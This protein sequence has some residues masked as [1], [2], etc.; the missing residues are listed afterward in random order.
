MLSFALLATL[1]AVPITASA[2]G[3]NLKFNGNGKFKIVIFSDVQDQFPVHQRVIRI[4]EQALARENPDL[5]VFLGDITELNIKDPEDDY[6][7]TVEQIFA[8]VVNAGIPYAIVFGNH[9]DQSATSGTRTDKE[10]MLSVIQSL[11]DCR[12]VDADPSLFG[13]GTCKIPIY[14]SSGNSVAFDLF[15]VDSNTYQTPTDGNSGYDNPHADQL[16]WLAANKDAGVNSLVFQ[17]IP[18]PEIYNLLTVD[19]GGSRTYGNK[20]YAMSLNSNASGSLG[21]FPCPPRYNDNTGEFAALKSM[22]GVLGVITGHDHLNDFT[23]TYDGIKMTAVPGMTYFNYG[24]ET[25]RGYGVIE[26]DESDL[27]TYNNHTVKF[28]E[29][30]AESGISTVTTFD[31]YDVITYA[32]LRKNGNPLSGDTYT[33][34]G[35]NDFSYNATSPSYSAIFKFRWIAGTNTGIQFSFDFGNGSNISYPFGVWVKKPNDNSAGENGAWHLK[36]SAPKLI[37][38]MASAVTEGDI[39]DIEIGRLKVLT[40]APQHLGEYYIYLKVNGEL[41]SWTY[42]NTSED[43]QYMSGGAL[44]QVSNNIRFADWG[45]YGNKISAYAEEAYEEYDVVSY[46]DLLDTGNHAL[47]ADGTT[48]TAKNNVFHYDATSATHSAV[49]KFRWVAGNNNR[50]QVH[51]G[52]YG[53]ANNFAYRIYDT[54]LIQRNPEKILA[55]DFDINEGDE[56]DI[57]VA[58][59]MT[60]AGVNAGKYYTYFKVNGVTVFAKCVSA[61]ESNTTSYLSDTLQMNLNDDSSY[62]TIKP[63]PEP[64]MGPYAAYDVIT[65]SDLLDTGNNHLSAGGKTLTAQN[66]LF[67]Y[68][69]TSSTHSVI[70]KFR[71]VAGAAVYFQMF[72]GAYRSGDPFAYRLKDDAKT[73]EKRYSPG[74]ASKTLGHTVTEGET[75]DFEIA[76]LKVIE[77]ENAGKYYT[78]LKANDNL[79][80]EEYVTSDKISG[81]DLDDSIQLNLNGSNSCVIMA[82]PAELEPSDAQYYKYDEIDYEDLLYNGSALSSETTLGNRVLT[83]YRTSPTYSAILR[84]RWKAASPDTQFQL[85]FDRLGAQNAINYMFGIQLYSAAADS[86]NHPNGRVW[87]RPGYGPSVDFTK[88]VQAGSTYDIEFARL[89]VKNGENAG[90][91][92]MYF[93]MNG[94]LI[95][96]SYVAADV[97]DDSGNYVSKPNDVACHLSNEIYITYWG[98]GGNDKICAIPEEDTFVDYDEVYYSDLLYNGSPVAAERS[99]QGRMYTYNKTS[100][101]G[102]AIL[103]IRWKNADPATQFQISFDRKGSNNAINYMFGVQLY[104]ASAQYP[105]GRVYLRPGYGPSVAFT[106]PIQAG[107]NYD[108]EFARLKVATGPNA[109]KYY[110]YFKMNDVL[111]AEDYVAANVVDSVGNYTSSPDSTACHISNEMYITFWGGSGSTITNPAYSETYYDYDEVGYED[112]LLG[113]NP[114]TASRT[115]LGSTR[116]FTYNRTSDTYSV[117]LKYCWTAGTYASNK[118]YYVFYFDAWAGSAYPFA[119]AVKSPGY[120]SLGAAAGANGAWHIDPSAA[121]NIVQ[122]STPIVTGNNY[123]IEHGRIKVKTGPQKD[124]YYVYLKVD[125]V[126]VFGYYYDGVTGNTYKNGAGTLTN[127]LKFTSGN[128]TSYISSATND[129]YDTTDQVYYSDLSVGGSPVE[130]ERSGSGTTYTY[131]KTSSSGSAILKIR[132]KNANPATQ[133]QMSFDRKGS[134]N[135]INYMFGVQLFTPTT[136]Y[137]NGYVWLRPGYGPKAALLA[138][139][140]EGQN[141]DIE[142]ARIKVMGGPNAGKYYMYIKINNA[143]IAEDYFDSSVVD[144]GGNYNSYPGPVNCQ[145]SNKIYI[146][147][148]GG[149]GATITEPETFADYDIVNFYDLY[150]NGNRVGNELDMGGGGRTFTF[151]QTSDT[152]STILKY[153]WRV[154]GGT[155]FQLSFDT[156]GG[157]GFEY[158]F[159]AQLFAPESGYPNGYIWMRPGYG[160]KIALSSAIADGDYYNVEYA[161][162]KV[163]DG[164]YAGK[165]CLY[166]KIGDIFYAKEYFGVSVT[167]GNYTSKPGDIVCSI[168]NEIYLTFWGA[169]SN[170]KITNYREATYNHTGL[171][172]DLNGDSSV[173]ALDLQKL[174]KAVVDLLDMSDLPDGVADYNNDGDVSVFDMVAMKKTFI[175]TNSYAKSGSLALGMQ[176]HLNEDN[177]KTAQYIADASATLGASVYRLSM[178]IHQLYYPTATNNAS[179]RS[180]NMDTF[181]SMVSA[182]KAKGITKILYVTD[183]FILPYGY[184]NQYTNHNKTVPNPSTDT[185]NYIAWLKVN[186]DAFGKLAAEVPEIHFF[187]PYNEVN[188][189]DTRLEKPGIPWDASSSTQVY[190]RYTESERAGI[191]ADLCWY[192]TR[193]VKSVDPTNQVTTPSLAVGTEGIIENS[194]LNALYGAIKTGS[195]PIGRAAGDKRIDNFFTIVNIHTYPTYVTSGLD[196]KVNEAANNIGSNIYSVMQAHGDGNS[197]VWLTE[198]GVSVFGSRS[199]ST[200]ASLITKFL[201]KINNNLTYIDTVIFYK[202]ADIST[203]VSSSEAERKFGLF[204]SGDA[205]SNDYG[206]KQTAKAVYT[207]FH[208]GSTDYTAL[209]NLRNRWH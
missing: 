168:S 94:V 115:D 182:L 177:T 13:T 170:N 209:T 181:K 37:T 122:M 125:N 173:N 194:F 38:D 15:M 2:D 180:D 208:N 151:N 88:T 64:D 137:P 101:S 36:P 203:S 9:D 27:S 35:R 106:E 22:G 156:L 189:S 3:A 152:G 68:N 199:E 59:I 143:L 70:Y 86:A 188:L 66:N 123:I 176:E 61:S 105:N 29:L 166:L 144:S 146:T 91:Y 169:S 161:R 187:E 73:W 171:I 11:G 150:L 33:F 7:R 118:P 134:E 100:E 47:S 54:N 204:Y 56:F 157:N 41:I 97:V 179:V 104:S 197:R 102:S 28:S 145:I 126:L 18:M 200:A 65:Y 147:F 45:S 39:Y 74:A 1:C 71:Y 178:P 10:A 42:T 174:S 81:T 46:Y 93:K 206:A 190:Y 77:G 154:G 52:G 198:T 175:Q 121:A 163:I 62:C 96:E 195:Y 119:L 17:H 87:L 48:L 138:P 53:S 4:M 99:G 108:I 92:Y 103:K 164:K 25:V 67:H 142:F 162:L 112:F 32:D 58:R 20:T 191:M 40:G 49:Y 89:K 113:G 83:Y 8:P 184:A 26:L 63:I 155:K 201:N 23:G 193:A 72:P 139:I 30:D 82:T 140:T 186:A 16:A 107:Q 109:G 34:N 160:N 132:W 69:A 24:N 129:S 202:V 90:K 50:F 133:F 95:A 127:I 131:N 153:R 44:C 183:S 79:I 117:V 205:S 76:R 130:S 196:N 21:E 120:S 167:D 149:N 84:Y 60:T 55:L 111:I 43:G 141:Y 172:G 31:S 192:V 148:W 128:A 159:G 116:D 207:F 5:V 124:K 57:E 165:Y 14:S 51:P 78:Y 136:E 158:M 114:V 110:M 185:E 135:A 85:S 80:F 19:A 6:R 75:I 98:G 12:T